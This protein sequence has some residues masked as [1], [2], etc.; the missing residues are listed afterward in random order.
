MDQ[1][2]GKEVINYHNRWALA[3]TRLAKGTM[4]WLVYNATNWGYF[5]VGPLNGLQWP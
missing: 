1:P 5:N 2:P 4:L 3:A